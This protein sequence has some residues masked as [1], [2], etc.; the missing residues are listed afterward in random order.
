MGFVFMCSEG[1][2][3]FQDF[4]MF[5]KKRKER[6]RLI[7]Q[8]VI[9]RSAMHQHYCLLGLKINFEVILLLLRP[10]PLERNVGENRKL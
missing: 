2:M 3:S 1:E 9:S 4:I 8:N 5:K 6:G 7:P 10:K